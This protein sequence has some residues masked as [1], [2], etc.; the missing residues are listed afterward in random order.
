MGED[1]VWAGPDAELFRLRLRHSGGGGRPVPP[2]LVQAPDRVPAS[3][4]NGRHL[5][6]GV[7][8][9]CFAPIDNGMPGASGGREEKG[10]GWSLGRRCLHLRGAGW[11]ELG[12]LQR[13]GAGLA[14][15]RL[16]AGAEGAGQEGRERS[17]GRVD[18]VGWG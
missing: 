14:A 13:R 6:L 3:L 8:V 9:V 15:G 4:I 16:W 5:L 10:P 12:A 11:V 17:E 7:R 1:V 18:R 2:G